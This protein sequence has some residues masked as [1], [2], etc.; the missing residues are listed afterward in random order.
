MV[1]CTGS[2]SSWSGDNMPSAR[3]TRGGSC[4]SDSQASSVKAEGPS[5]IHRV[6]DLLCAVFAP[7]CVHPPPQALWRTGRGRRCWQPLSL[8]LTTC[9]AHTCP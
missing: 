7:M 9:H 4:F 5:R 6:T 8:V 3:G 1:M 2:S